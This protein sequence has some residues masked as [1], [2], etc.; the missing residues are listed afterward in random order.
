MTTCTCKMQVLASLKSDKV[1]AP[2]HKHYKVKVLKV[3]TFSCSCKCVKRH[4]DNKSEHSDWREEIYKPKFFKAH[5]YGFEPCIS[6]LILKHA[7]YTM[8]SQMAIQFYVLSHANLCVYLHC[9]DKGH[10]N[11]SRYSMN[12]SWCMTL[13]SKCLNSR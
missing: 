5:G 8:C 4:R 12:T 1:L 7:R 10:K 9:D 13:I 2:L 6:L 3:P 11:F